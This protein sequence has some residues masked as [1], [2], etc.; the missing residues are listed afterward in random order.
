L[1][2]G[3]CQ[4]LSKDTQKFTNFQ[5]PGNN[6]R[7]LSKRKKGCVNYQVTKQGDFQLPGIV[8]QKFHEG[9]KNFVN[10]SEKTKIFSKIIYGVTL[11]PRYY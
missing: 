2:P 7:K 8:T 11:G 10:V 5:S 4:F 9:K 1:L 3:D 6:N